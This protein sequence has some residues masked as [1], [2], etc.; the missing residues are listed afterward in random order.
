MST[1]QRLAR[2]TEA[3]QV[4]HAPWWETQQA[5]EDLRALLKERNRYR[6]ALEEASEHPCTGGGWC[7]SCTA[8]AA[9]DGDS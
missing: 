3:S 5:M 2:M 9:L 6:E 4:G 7:A 1:E 8:R